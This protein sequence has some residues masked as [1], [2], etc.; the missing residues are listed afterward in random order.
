MS[1]SFLNI[2][3]NVHFI[4]CLSIPPI[5]KVPEE[6][7]ENISDQ[8]RQVQEMPKRLDEFNEEE[9][10]KFPKLFDW[11]AIYIL[12][13]FII[14]CYCP[15]THYHFPNSFISLYHLIEINFLLFAVNITFY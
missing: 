5:Q 7:M 12:I 1:N 13:Y 10:E 3:F 2:F 8:I 6:I 4:V 14:C 15:K 11:L 9:I